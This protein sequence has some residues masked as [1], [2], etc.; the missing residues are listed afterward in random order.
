MKKAIKEGRGDRFELQKGI[1][2]ISQTLGDF[3]AIDD[4]DDWDDD[5]DDSEEE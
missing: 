3:E 1:E 5:E 2:S 4:W